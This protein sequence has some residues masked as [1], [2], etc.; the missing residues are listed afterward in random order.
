MEQIPEFI[1]LQEDKQSASIELFS[2]LLKLDIKEKERVINFIAASMDLKTI[3][4]AKT[5]TGKSY[6]GLKKFGN[7]IRLIGRNYIA[8]VK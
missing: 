8:L 5:I 2:Q 7:V 3:P 4:E 1:D 6:N